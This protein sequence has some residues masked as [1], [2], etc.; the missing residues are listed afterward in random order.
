MS[1]HKPRFPAPLLVPALLAGACTVAPPADEGFVA[2]EDGSRIRY[3]AAGDSGP[4]VMIPMA[5][6]LAD[7]LRPLAEGRRLVFYDPRGRGPS[8]PAEPGTA[9]E[10]REIRDM[11]ALRSALGIDSMALLG[12]SGL[13]KQV[14]VYAVRYPQRVTQIVQVS[15]VPPSSDSYPP[16]PG[17][18]PRESRIDADSVRALDERWRAGRFGDDGA[19]YCRA[20]RELTL[21]ASFADTSLHRHAPDLCRYQNEWPH[22]LSRYFGEL[23][24]SFGEYDWRD[25]IRALGVPRLVIHGRQDGVPLS[26]ARAW[27]AG[28]PNARLL[29]L[30]PAGHFPFL[31]R[32]DPFLRAIELFLDGRWPRGAEAVPAPPAT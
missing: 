28:D 11:E 18:P 20:R 14:A 29:V 27:V 22:N 32:P 4:V 6:Y 2:T 12:W 13:A 5:A 19:A 9:T 31:E 10:D 1:V 3:V 17:A 25:S 21:P 15:P 24:P 30:S 7:P 23:L 16:E 26:G 8:D